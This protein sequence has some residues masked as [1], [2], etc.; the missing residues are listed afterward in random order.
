MWLPRRRA[1]RNPC[2]SSIRQTSRP[3]RTR[4]LPIRRFELGHEDLLSP[5]LL[6]LL[7]VRG[8]EKQIHSFSQVIEGHFDRLALARDVELGT[9]GDVGIAL[10]FDDRR[11]ETRRGGCH[12]TNSLQRLAKL[13]RP[14]P[15]CE[16]GSEEG[17]VADNGLYAADA[18]LDALRRYPFVTLPE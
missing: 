17:A 16:E 7:R 6:N 13:P 10:S 11:K 12:D 1:S 5:S 15:F 8:F 2:C 14:A 4:S 18:P 3:E 9:K